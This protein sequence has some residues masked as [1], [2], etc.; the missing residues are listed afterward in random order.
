MIQGKDV[1]LE[2]K[3]QEVQ[4]ACITEVETLSSH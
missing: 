3:M 2:W 1:S 4:A